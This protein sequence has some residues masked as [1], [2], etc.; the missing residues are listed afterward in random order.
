MRVDVPAPLAG[1]DEAG[2]G[3]MRAD[4][5]AVVPALQSGSLFGGQEG[6]LLVDAQSLLK[7]EAEI[8]V[9]EGAALTF[10][11]NRQL[12][13][14]S[15]EGDPYSTALAL[16]ALQAGE[17]LALPDLTVEGFVSSDP[18]PAPGDSPGA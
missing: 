4:L 10:L 1:S 3:A 2:D 13:N 5:E 11:E 7:A 16:Q 15:W 12:A 8:T 6:V 18:A 14:G 9:T 17:G